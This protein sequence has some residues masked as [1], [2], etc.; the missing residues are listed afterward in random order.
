M[1]TAQNNIR[2]YN[3]NR[4]INSALLLDNVISQVTKIF[5][6][7]VKKIGYWNKK[8]SSRELLR[9]LPDQMLKDIGISR[10]DAL[11]ESDKKFWQ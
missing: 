6:D 11:I 3:V 8:N 1:K 5:K 4:N 7:S 2:F 9:T 10:L